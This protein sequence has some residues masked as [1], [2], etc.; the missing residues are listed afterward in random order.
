MPFEVL[1]LIR[2]EARLFDVA[3]NLRPAGAGV[4]QVCVE[5][6]DEHPGLMGVRG[7]LVAVREQHQRA[8]ADPEFDPWVAV[9]ALRLTL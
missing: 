5:I 3:D 4:V 1:G 9:A 7:C 8:V 6:V 2:A